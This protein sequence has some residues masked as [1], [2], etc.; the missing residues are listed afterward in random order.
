MAVT[1][2]VVMFLACVLWKQSELQGIPSIS[3]WFIVVMFVG[4]GIYIILPTNRLL[5]T[6]VAEQNEAKR[7]LQSVL[8][9]I[10]E[11]VV[12]FKANG[13]LLLQNPTAITL[14][15]AGEIGSHFKAWNEAIGLFDPETSSPLSLEQTPIALALKGETL[16]GKL[17]II[18]KPRPAATLYVSVTGK[19]ML[20]EKGQH[21]GAV[22]SFHNV[23]EQVESEMELRRAKTAAEAA[24]RSKS[25]FLAN[26]SHEI[27]TPMT[28]IL[29]YADLCLAPSLTPEQRRKNVQ[30]IRSNGRM[31][32]QLIEDILDISKIEAGR[33]DIEKTPVVLQDLLCEVY[34][35]LH[36]R[37]QERNVS[38]VVDLQGKLPRKVLTAPIRLRQILINIVG[39]AIKFTEKGEVSLKIRYL[40]NEATEEGQ[41]EFLVSDT[42]CGIPPESVDKLF[43]PFVQV[44]ATTTRQYGGTG[45]GLALS[46]RLARA[47]GG[48]LRLTASTPG[49]GSTFVATIDSGPVD[50]S[51]LVSNMRINE[52]RS[53]LSQAAAM[54]SS[55]LEGIKVL[56]VEDSP[57]NRELFT[58]YLESAGA[59]VSQANDGEQ[60]VEKA[61]GE[62]FDVVLMDIQM[63]RM[64]G[65]QAVATLREKSYPGPVIALTAHAMEDE[66]N[67]C[68]NA[69]FNDCLTKPIDP[70]IL[71]AEVRRRALE[72]KAGAFP[73]RIV[74]KQKIATSS[75]QVKSI[76][77]RFVHSIPA[78][79]D[80]MKRA[81][82]ASDWERL[83]NLAHRFQGTAGN[84]GFPGLMDKASELEETV[85]AGR[86]DSALTLHLQTLEMIG[87]LSAREFE[88]LEPLEGHHKGAFD[89][90]TASLGKLVPPSPY[91]RES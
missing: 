38:F 91:V 42:G 82:E 33:T 27:R 31:L 23:T 11:A 52:V 60:G 77:A 59:L 86:R 70:A 72:A 49:V 5:H 87:K 85:R 22:I 46:R 90:A 26:M 80:G 10:G 43:S 62:R 24:S 73:E 16:K 21:Q 3:L 39:N 63:P 89:F 54:P 25:E 76:L 47:L 81:A 12:V 9:N 18:K 6:Q 83:M 13:T 45:L 79:I 44:D 57:E 53:D 40:K 66:K 51:E 19:P 20:D 88:R 32:M 29:G 28:A 34:S 4:M 74:D 1:A 48:D 36:C 56:V 8:D 17:M 69:G 84:C 14:L 71:V 55:N 75:S 37:A 78:E 61:L 35:P 50:E 41:L 68:A 67:R 2:M 30:I 64:D 58:C 7:I 15:A 65:Y